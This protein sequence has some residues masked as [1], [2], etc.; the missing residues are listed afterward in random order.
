[1]PQRCRSCLYGGLRRP[2]SAD[3]LHNELEG[4]QRDHDS[5]TESQRRDLTATDQF[6]GDCARYPEGVPASS[7]VSVRRSWLWGP[8]SHR[9]ALGAREASL[10]DDLLRAVIETVGDNAL[11]REPGLPLP[12]IARTATPYLYLVWPSGAYPGDKLGVTRRIRYTWT[13]EH[14]YKTAGQRTHRH[15]AIRPGGL[16]PQV[17]GFESQGGYARRPW[18][19]R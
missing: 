15:S 13:D 16:N 18:S 5:S 10:A 6:V 4:V 14:V 8:L 19:E 3:A 2:I 1:M 9:P 11:V 7:T 17:L 12:P